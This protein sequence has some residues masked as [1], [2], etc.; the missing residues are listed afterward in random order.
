MRD[1]AARLITH[2]TRA[3][4]VN[5][6]APIAFAVLDE[7]RNH[8]TTLMGNG[9]HRALLMR[10]LALAGAEVPWLRGIRVA[11]DGS[12]EGSGSHAESIDH[13]ERTEGGVVLIA[14]LM[15]LLVAFIGEK[16]TLQLVREVW[17]KLPDKDLNFKI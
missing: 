2:E 6:E 17:P 10:A 15:G 5:F 11:A 14:Q 9:G 1:F 4:A 3:R 16:L 8:L 12:L 13:D 7:M